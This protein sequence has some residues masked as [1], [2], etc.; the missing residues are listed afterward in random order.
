MSINQ[1]FASIINKQY[2][3]NKRAFS[4][5]IGVSPT[6]IENVVGKRQGNP[7]FE[8]VQ[9]VLCAN[10]NINPDWLIN[11]VGEMF[12]TVNGQ[13]EK[14]NVHVQEPI[15]GYI[16]GENIADQ[17]K[18]IP[19][20]TPVAVAGIWNGDF[21]I[22]NSDIKDYYVV[23][24]FKDRKI[25]FMIEV[26]GSSM[27]PRY[28]NGDVVACA[29]L[30]E[31]RFIQWNKVHVISTKEQGIL[32]KRIKKGTDENHLLLVS[33]NK[34]FEPFLINVDEITGIANVVGV[35]RLE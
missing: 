33:D 15:I 28:S 1:R 20:V 7:S 2:S 21:T 12:R 3:G 25:D 5:T 23:P 24:L 9:K 27:Y 19:L 31:S 14:K 18:R 30:R 26:S 17:F 8:V 29:I 22:N 13:Q 34:E 16:S 6:V 32:I 11:D 10:A 4:I 35:I